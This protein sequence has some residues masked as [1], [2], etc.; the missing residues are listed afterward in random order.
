MGAD[1]P[2]FIPV[3]VTEGDRGYVHHK[4]GLNNVAILELNTG[5]VLEI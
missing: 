4:D 5:T 2:E 1:A 3:F